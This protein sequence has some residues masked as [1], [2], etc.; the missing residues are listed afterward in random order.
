MIIIR[1]I[2]LITIIKTIKI[3]KNIVIISLNMVI[4]KST[5]SMAIF[6]SYVTMLVYQKVSWNMVINNNNNSHRWT[7]NHHHI[8]IHIL[9]TISEWEC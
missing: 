3:I 9:Q 6:N 5:I 1:L 7:I 4:N 8:S 2:S